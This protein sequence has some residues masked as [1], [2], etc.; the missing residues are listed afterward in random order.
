MASFHVLS[1]PSMGDTLY[2]D[3]TITHL[4]R[5]DGCDMC[6]PDEMISR[7]QAR[8]DCQDGCYFI[9][10]L[11]SRNGT[12]VNDQRITRRIQLEDGDEVLF[13]ESLVRF[14][15]HDARS[16]AVDLS[17]YLTVSPPASGSKAG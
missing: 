1:G 17:Y 8:I 14:Q 11:A 7:R 12:I 13:G 6:I 2:F 9:E 15:L 10:D 3:R 16:T 5:D 4:G